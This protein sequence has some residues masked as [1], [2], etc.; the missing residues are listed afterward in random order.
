MNYEKMVK[1]SWFDLT[2]ELFKTSMLLSD[3]TDISLLEPDLNITDISLLESNLNIT[4]ILLLEPD[5]NIT[6]IL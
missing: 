4:D 3:I 6:D 1:S 2:S 5:L